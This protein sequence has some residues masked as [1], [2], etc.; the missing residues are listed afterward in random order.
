MVKNLENTA[1]K[2]GIDT[3]KTGSERVKQKP[4]NTTGGR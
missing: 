4:A 3:A 2:K 1:R